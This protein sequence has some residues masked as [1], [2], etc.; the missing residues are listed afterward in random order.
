MATDIVTALP[1][2]GFKFDNCLR[3]AYLTSKGFPVPKARKTGTTIVGAVFKDAVI[4]G[5]DTRATSGS[6]VADKNSMKIH[7]LAPN[8][9]CCGAGTAADTEQVTNMISSQLELHRLATDRTVPVCVAN[10]LL[11]QYL[12]RYQGHI[13]AALIVGGVDSSGPSV[14]SI[15]PHGSYQKQ[16]YDC[17]GSGSLAAMTVFET[18][19]KT[20]M[21]IDEGKQ[22]VRDAINA[23]IFNDLGSGS[24]VDLCIITKNG[25]EYLRPY[26]LSGV[27]G[28]ILGKY[29][30]APGTTAILSSQTIPLEIE[31]TTVK[32]DE[33][34]DIEP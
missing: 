14:Y 7:Y 28:P 4:L 21:S 8:M 13:G 18:R 6:I 27:K 9:Y 12:F 5:A 19:W 11:C 24:T 29:V 15:H 2:S 34:M 23:G 20:D 32:L 3:N 17:M 10:R 22:L 30:Y 33:E 25:V 1:T 16:P 31:T 26:E